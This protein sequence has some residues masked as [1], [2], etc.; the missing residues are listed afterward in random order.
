[1]L[2]RFSEEIALQGYSPKT[3]KTYINIIKDFLNSGK[4]PRDFLLERSSKSR[5]TL[6]LS[7][8]ALKFFHEKILQ[9]PFHDQLPLAKKQHSLPVVL[10]RSEVQEMIKVGKNYKHQLI[11]KMLY[12]SGMRLSELRNLRWNDID[13]ERKLIHIHMGKES[14]D[15]VVFLHEQLEEEL[16]KGSTHSDFI[17]TSERGGKYTERSIQEIIK[18]AAR[19]AG[20]KK[21]VSP[22]TLRHSFATHLLE[23]GADIRYIQQLLGHKDLKTTQIY[24][25]IANKEIKNLA[26]LL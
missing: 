24:T 18:Q 3:E 17:F 13:Y 7:Y 8:F 9:Q 25:H 10:N 20:I 19:K 6:R 26:K 15:R 23:S 22:H 16:R 12:Y 21:K 5:S 1:M 11:V 2:K 14:K 4:T